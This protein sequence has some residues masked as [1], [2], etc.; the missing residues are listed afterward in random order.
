MAGD[1]HPPAAASPQALVE[2]FARFLE[3]QHPAAPRLATWATALLDWLPPLLLEGR[4]RLSRLPLEERRA[5][6]RASLE[7]RL[8]PRRQLVAQ[9]RFLVLTVAY[10]RPDL[11]AAVGYPG[12]EPAQEAP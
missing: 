10:S 5:F 12:P 9:L 6:L 1:A 4:S 7:S 8:P 11:S 2:D 3:D